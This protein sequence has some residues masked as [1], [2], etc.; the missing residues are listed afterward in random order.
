VKEYCKLNADSIRDLKFTDKGGLGKKVEFYI[1]GRLPNN[2]RNPD[3]DFGDI[4]TTHIK[5][6]RDG[7]VLKKD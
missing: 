5:K 4:K 2:D 6:C 1:F 7:F 3:T